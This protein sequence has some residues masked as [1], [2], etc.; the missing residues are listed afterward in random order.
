MN[1]IISFSLGFISAS[2]IF[3]A[4]AAYIKYLSVPRETHTCSHARKSAPE[5]ALNQKS[6]NNRKSVIV[7]DDKHDK[8]LEDED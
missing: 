1:I 8:D 7:L 5:L 4:A 6:A 3:L 2:A